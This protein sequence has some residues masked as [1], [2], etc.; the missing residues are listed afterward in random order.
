M[1]TMFKA[2][3][4]V[5]IV[6][7]EKDTKCN[8]CGRQ[9]K[10]GIKLADCAGVF[11]AQCLAKA[12]KIVPATAITRKFKVTPDMI[13]Q[14]AIVAGKGEKYAVDNYGWKLDSKVFKFELEKDLKFCD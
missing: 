2:E 3:E 9:L 14:R 8:H 7:F 6:G 5:Q 1:H 12:F 11:G 4:I 10:L 13:K